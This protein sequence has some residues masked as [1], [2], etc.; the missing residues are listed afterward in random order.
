MNDKDPPYTGPERR[1][2][3]RRKK[4]DRRTDIRFEPDKED[5]R[6]KPGR[7]KTDGDVWKQHE[8]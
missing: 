1:E 7:R 5:R 2:E 3:N 8:E 6:R 4:S